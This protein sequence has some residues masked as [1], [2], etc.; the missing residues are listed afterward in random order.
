MLGS[1]VLMGGLGVAIGAVLVIASKAFYVYEDPKVVAI[2][3]ALPGANCGGCGLPGCGAN[4][5][6][7]VKGE[8]DVN[9]CVAAGADVAIAIAEIMGVSVTDKEPEF[10]DVGCY[11]SLE[12]ADVNYVYTGI[13]DCR[14]ATLLSG[15]AKTCR[16]GCIGLG[17]CVKACPFGA[18]K[19]E[20]GGLPEV[21]QD[22]CTGCGTCE[23]ICP[24]H[25][26]KMTSVTRRI[27]REYTLEDCVTPCQRACPTGID[28]REYIRLIKNKEYRKSLEVIKERNPF[29]TVISRIC[30]AVCEMN[31]R[32]LLQDEPVAINHLKRFVC[33]YDMNQEQRAIPY[34]APETEKKVAVI[35]G[36]VEGL[37]A[38]YFSAR[39]GHH[40]TV[41][42]ST[43]LPGGVLRTAISRKRLKMDILDWD[44]Q[45]VVDM[46]VEIR[47]QMK[48]GKDFTIWGLLSQGN[49]AVYT[50]T[51]GWDS[52]L[53]R[54]ENNEVPKVI[55]GT[56]LLIDVLRKET[57]SAFTDVHSDHAVIVGGETS[58][59]EAVECL[60]K[61][62]VKA[63]TIVSRNDAS[64]FG[65][66]TLEMLKKEGVTLINES[67]VTRLAGIEETLCSIECMNLKTGIK[68]TVDTDLLILASGRLPSLVFSKTATTEEDTESLNQF[69]MPSKGWEAIELIKPPENNLELGLLSNYDVISEYN[70]AVAAI[71][72]GRKA[73]AAIHHIMYTIPFQETA[74][75]VNRY[76]VLQD[77]QAIQQ[78]NIMPRNAVKINTDRADHQREAYEGF[79]EATALSESE[80]CLR[81]G[82]LC[83]ERSGKGN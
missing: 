67:G 52:R 82:L 78:V 60:K 21:D 35:G 18:L 19:I 50:A 44:I 24:K 83:Y 3:E 68:E 41:Y 5:E 29:P 65:D 54:N 74:N 55:P 4:A 30:P 37:S 48:A 17:T 43:A 75:L 73:A 46:G 53:A 38:A 39:L 31:C 15:G 56:Y 12:K 6:A 33:D 2:T 32:R 7:I 36:G 58:A 22:K 62:G 45:G 14:A 26:I 64:I 77:V 49:D 76:S 40:A 79:A 1:I 69:E 71:N 81:C 57:L 25:I 80:R 20:K 10:A 63:I 9:S 72:G 61:I 51:G 28:I 42:E 70:S 59:L 27:I 66:P 8:A 23:R 13:S 16:I 47:T 11:Y 34:K